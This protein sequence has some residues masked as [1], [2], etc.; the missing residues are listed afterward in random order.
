MSKVI[1]CGYNW[2]GCKVLELLLKMGHEVFVYTHKNPYYVNSLSTYC[3]LKQVRFSLEKITKDNLPFNPEIISSIYYRYL[4]PEDIIELVNGK[5]FNLHPSYLPDYKGCSSLTWALING[6]KS[7]GFSYH[8]ITKNFDEGNIIFQKKIKIEDFDNQTTL[9]NRCMFESVKYFKKAFK[10]VHNNYKGIVQ[11]K[12]EGRYY[13]R[14]CPYDGKINYNWDIKKVERFIRAMHYPPLP[15]ATLN[16]KEIKTIDE[17]LL[18]TKN[19]S[20]INN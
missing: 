2:T 13:K 3:T 18:L 20:E 11:P 17:Y 6:E 7:V 16:G 5:I 8:Y 1:L 9:Y 19:S 12:N 14:G 4:I 15:C 10:L